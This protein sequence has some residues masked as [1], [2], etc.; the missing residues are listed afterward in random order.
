MTRRHQLEVLGALLVGLVVLL[1]LTNLSLRRSSE[2]IHEEVG[3]DLDTLRDHYAATLRNAE[4]IARSFQ[5][6]FHSSRA[7]DGDQ[8]RILSEE[9][10]AGYPAIRE[11]FWMPRVREHA[12]AT[13]FEEL[14]DAGVVGFQIF[15]LN[16]SGMR[17]EVSY[18][19]DAYPIV[20]AEPFNGV[21]AKAIGLV[22]TTRAEIRTA[23]EAAIRTGSPAISG[24]TWLLTPGERT[25]LMV[26][27]TYEGKSTPQSED[28]RVRT[29]NGLV[30][31]AMDLATAAPQKSHLDFDLVITANG[32]DEVLAGSRP[33]GPRPALVQ[34]MEGPFT[35]YQEQCMTI[36][37]RSFCLRVV[38][39]MRLSDLE[40]GQLFLALAIGA[41]FAAGL[42]VIVRNRIALKQH[43]Q[44]LESEVRE[45]TAAIRAILDNVS[46]GLFRCDAM[47]RILPGHSASVPAILDAG[48]EPI[49][50]RT[51]PSL[52]S[53][54]HP[55]A[56]NFAALYEQVFEDVAHEEL[57]LGQ[58]PSR[59]TFGT[60][61]LKLTPSAIRDRAGRVESVLFVLEDITAFVTAER[62]ISKT[63]AIIK[64]LNSR[65]RFQGLVS[66]IAKTMPRLREIAGQPLGEKQCRLA[67][68]T[69]KGNFASFGV[70][71]LA[72]H[73]HQI[74]DRTVITR[75]DVEG[76]ESI[77]LQFLNENMSALDVRYG[78]PLDEV[79]S[80]SEQAL[81]AL[82]EQILQARDSENVM[83]LVAE[84]LE[85]SRRK[86]AT[87]LLGPMDEVC[88][89]LATRFAKKAQ[90]QLRGGHV[91]VPPAMS[92][93][94]HNVQ[95]L[96]RNALDHG[97][98]PPGRRGQKPTE[99]MVTLS[100]IEEMSEYVL[101]FCDDGAGIDTER[102]AERA[103]EMGL[104]TR[105]RA[106]SLT[107]QEKIEL[108]F[109]PGLSTVQNGSDISGR[110]IGMSAVLEAVDHFRGS[111]LVESEPRLGTS[112]TIR[113]PKESVFGR[114]AA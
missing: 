67:L 49:E 68:H 47:L 101:I 21:G 36:A 104:V 70:Q 5:A 98:E 85:L 90:F 59:L 20:H 81:R 109:H 107:R 65:D 45:R 2:K 91:R 93:L 77:L 15:T 114:A 71:D 111:I 61:T 80:V 7:V 19:H 102:V 105:E 53:L 69:W 57:T 99:G 25:L 88:K 86:T 75:A 9:F 63:R 108:I 10:R 3:Q 24:P 78:T 41:A 32:N 74:E 94:L 17:T 55:A 44:H 6:V 82:E 106:R 62:E 30:A 43:N 66:E 60:R 38:R 34:G 54:S 113:V 79:Y 76:F 22:P 73:I 39:D 35:E 13:F 23:A 31:I 42:G 83:R 100:L 4:A 52:L 26:V 103:I 14:E 95:H 8:F 16:D 1:F 18:D 64:I 50:G 40:W 37:T 72:D 28:E 112:I 87:E 92:L 11:L 110:G 56:E 12:S 27:P 84:F 58:L 29:V 89:T 48:N 96:M 97:I 33:R 46:F 51:L